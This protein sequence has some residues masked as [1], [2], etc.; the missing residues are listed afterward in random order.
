M[1]ELKKQKNNQFF[2]INIW[3]AVF[4]VAI[5]TTVKNLSRQPQKLKFTNLRYIL[6]LQL[7]QI[8]VIYRR[9]HSYSESLKGSI[10][11]VIVIVL[12]FWMPADYRA[13]KFKQYNFNL[14]SALCILMHLLIHLFADMIIVA[15]NLVFLDYL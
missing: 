8:I 10:K 6:L 5:A 2:S 7:L 14:E 12:F 4:A 3:I 9:E 11:P 15:H 13:V 1:Q